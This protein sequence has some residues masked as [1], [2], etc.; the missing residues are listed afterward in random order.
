MTLIS[1]SGAERVIQCAASVVLPQTYSSSDYADRGTGLHGFVRS[2]LTGIPIEAALAA[3]PPEYRGTAER[4]QWR[5]LGSDLSDVRT[6]VAYAIDVRARTARELGQNIGRHYERHA[7]TVDEMVGSDDIEGTRI[8]GVPVVLDMKFGY[9]R[10]APCEV[11]AQMLTYCLARYLLTGAPEIEG[12]ICYVAPEGSIW[13]DSYTFTAFDLDGFADELEDAFD[14]V[15]GARRVYLAREDLN[16]ATGEHC[17]YCGAMESCPAYVKLARAML[18]E[19][20]TLE[21]AVETLTLD[22]AGVAWR[23]ARDIEKL[24]DRVLEALKAR[25]R[26][27][28]L[29][30]G[31]DKC[32]KEISYETGSFNREGALALLKAKGATDEEVGMLYTKAL[33]KSVR[34]GNLPGVKRKRA[35]VKPRALKAKEAT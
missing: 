14:R 8:D 29:P 10:V 18:P 25:A 11:N 5:K 1:A 24:L 16:V 6:E 13:V 7:I 20:L 30:L 9:E 19:A 28:P 35:A 4:I 22:Q 32:V 27:E 31:D 23:K 3:L 33:I 26:Q 12:R 15:A 34:E 17:R 2:V 21:A